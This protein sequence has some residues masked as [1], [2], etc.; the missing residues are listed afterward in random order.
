MQLQSETGFICAFA[1]LMNNL[2]SPIRLFKGRYSLS[3]CALTLISSSSHHT[4]YYY[5]MADDSVILACGKIPHEILAPLLE[6]LPQEGVLVPPSI[7]LDACGIHTGTNFISVKA[8]PITMAKSDCG[9]QRERGWGVST[10]MCV[11]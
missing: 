7:G 3:Q 1:L 10:S 8:D 11:K 6:S 5:Y 9:K 2:I 4:Y